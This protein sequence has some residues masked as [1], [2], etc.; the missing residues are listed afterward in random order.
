MIV[1]LADIPHRGLDVALD[2]S[3]WARK[4]AGEGLGGEVKAFAGTFAITRHGKHAAVVGEMH[5]VGEVACDRCGAPLVVSLGGELSC[6]YSPLSALPERTSDDEGL[7]RPPVSLDFEVEDVGEFDGENL[8]LAQVVREWFTVERPARL[9]CAD[10]DPDSDSSC[11]DRFRS[12]AGPV[13]A[14]PVDP[15]LAVLSKLNVK[16]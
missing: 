2:H 13:T 14:P 1:A 4:A 10:V 16:D 12:L 15:R 9:V 8:D 11:R 3:A 5:A 7:P 6:L